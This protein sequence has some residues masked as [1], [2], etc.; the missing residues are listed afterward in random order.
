MQTTKAKRKRKG[1]LN[2]GKNKKK[3]PSCCDRGESSNRKFKVQK[4]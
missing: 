3:A 4:Q 1:H 2:G